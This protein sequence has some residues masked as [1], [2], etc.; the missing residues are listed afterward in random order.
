MMMG[1]VFFFTLAIDFFHKW[2]DMYRYTAYFLLF[3]ILSLLGFSRVYLGE[4]F[5][6]Q[7]IMGLCYS[8][9]YLT[10][11]F[12]FDRSLLD[13]TIKSS[14]NYKANR[15]YIVYWFVGTM[16]LLLASITVFDVITLNNSVSYT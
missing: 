5:P 7:V 13:L 3:L 15:K 14:F 12:A 1:T 11:V 10:A 9:I 8:F 4:Q 16:F 2:R 6:H